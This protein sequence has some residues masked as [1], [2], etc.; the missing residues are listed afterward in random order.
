LKTYLLSD[1]QAEAAGEVIASAFFPAPMTAFLFPDPDRRAQVLPLYSSA[2]TRVTVR[3]GKAVGVGDPLQA[4]AL[5]LPP[6]GENPPEEVSDEAGFPAIVALM[7]EAET[8]RAVALGAQFEAMAQRGIS[9]PHWY[10]AYLAVI[11]EQQGQG[12]G[13]ALARHSLDQLATTGLPCYLESANET[14]LSFYERLH[15]QVVEAGVVPDSTLRV[16]TLR[17]ARTRPAPNRL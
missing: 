5:W 11:P 15:F 16:W 10:L 8:V 14:N 4:V 3:T 1:D 6:G 12:L 13:A 9:G 7:D 17:R 2:M